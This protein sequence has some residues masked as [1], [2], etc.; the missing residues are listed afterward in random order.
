MNADSIVPLVKSKRATPPLFEVIV[1]WNNPPHISMPIGYPL[2][3]PLDPPSHEVHVPAGSRCIISPSIPCQPW[4][5][6]VPT[7]RSVPFVHNS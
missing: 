5:L 3:I 1:T 2:G 6:A 7:T 4:F